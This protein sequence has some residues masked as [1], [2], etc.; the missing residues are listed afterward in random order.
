[1]QN[2]PGRSAIIRALLGL[3]SPPR[4]TGL[5]A[6][7]GPCGRTISVKFYF[8]IN[9]LIYQFIPIRMAHGTGQAGPVIL[10]NSQMASAPLVIIVP[11]LM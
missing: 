4:W 8:N 9:E 5:T 1:M 10:Q 7:D 3:Q 2:L 6:I 11:Y